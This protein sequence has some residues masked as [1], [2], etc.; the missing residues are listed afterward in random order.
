MG[1]SDVLIY[2]LL[3][4]W[5]RILCLFVLPVACCCVLGETPSLIFGRPSDLDRAFTKPPLLQESRLTGGGSPNWVDLVE[6]KVPVE[7]KKG[8][9]NSFHSFYPWL[10]TCIVQAA[11][12]T[13]SVLLLLLFSSVLG[14]PLYEDTANGRATTHQLYSFAIEVWF[15][16]NG[17]FPSLSCTER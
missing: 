13:G 14:F 11:D 2:G 17:F 12:Q 4:Y 16:T 1:A 9:T 5:W 7:R 6:R 15:G 10:Y 3:F 8:A